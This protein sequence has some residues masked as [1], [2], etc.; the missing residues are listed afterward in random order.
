M[1]A[2]VLFG[3]GEQSGALAGRN[4]FPIL[5]RPLMTYPL[6]AARYARKVDAVA[7]STNSPALAEVA[8]SAGAAVIR[9]NMPTDEALTKS[10]VNGPIGSPRT[11]S[12]PA[13]K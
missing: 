12:P 9:R 11:H 4:T 2:V 3:I 8:T 13:S 7:I 6:L 1:I 5:G 10:Q